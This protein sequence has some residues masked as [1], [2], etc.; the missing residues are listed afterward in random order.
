M[1]AF[2]LFETKR[3]LELDVGGGVRVVRQFLV[4]VE[5]VVLRRNAQIRMPLQTRLF[6]VVEPFEL[7]SWFHEELHLHLLELAHTE[8]ELAG[9][10]LVAERLADLRNTKRQFHSACLVDI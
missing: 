7:L 10:N 3:E 4:I 5:T 2:Q 8:D 1:D 9:H 6:P